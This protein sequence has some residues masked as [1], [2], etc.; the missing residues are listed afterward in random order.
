MESTTIK[1]VDG[2]VVVNDVVIGFLKEEFMVKLHETFDN[3]A[4][5]DDGGDA[6]VCVGDSDAIAV[7]LGTVLA[8]AEVRKLFAV[9]R[10]DAAV[11]CWC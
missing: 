3:F 8:T 2:L 4:I 1:F 6:V 11:V 10:G 9:D 5:S 7:P